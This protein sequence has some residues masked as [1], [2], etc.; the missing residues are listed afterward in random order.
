MSV[1]GRLSETHD[2]ASTRHLIA[3]PEE[4]RRQLDRLLTSAHIRNSKRCRALLTHVVEA[5]LN[6]SHERIKER[7]LGTDVFHRPPNYDANEDSVVRTTALEIRKRLAQY[8]SEPGHEHELRVLLPPGSYV[9][10]FRLPAALPPIERE[11]TAVQ[12]PHKPRWTGLAAAILVLAGGVIAW[13]ALRP[14]AFDRFWAPLLDDRDDPLICIEQPLRIYRFEGPRFDELNRI[15]VGNGAIPPGSDEEREKA[16]IRLSELK[17]A[18]DRYFANGDMLSAMR[19]VEL[20]GRKGKSFL[21]LSDRAT[22]YHDLRGRPAVLIGEFNHIWLAGLQTGLRYS[23]DKDPARRLYMVRDGF[24]HG[25]VIASTTANEGRPE[26]YAIISRI[27]P[28]S[29]EKMMIMVAAFTFRGN[30]ASGDFL[31][32]PAYL[33]EAL[34]D[35][36]RGWERRNLQVVIKTTLVSGIAGPPKV[37]AKHYW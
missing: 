37:I 21:L 12:P 36:P 34:K 25:R 27:F 20:L 16:S 15:M 5:Y 35:A 11:T 33:R 23:L 32:K 1:T 6:G 7:T 8:Y 22:S 2:A 9:P 4:V 29:T 3:E 18:G 28:S 30:G 17:S 31:T 13:F 10:E 19:I 24:A 14:T 26:E